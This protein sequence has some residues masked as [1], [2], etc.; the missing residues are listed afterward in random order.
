M[1]KIKVSYIIIFMLLVVIVCAII[2]QIRKI[3]NAKNSVVSEINIDDRNVNLDSSL[4]NEREIITIYDIEDGYMDV[5]FNKKADLHNYDFQKHLTKENE[6]YRYEDDTYTSKVGIDVSSYQGVIDWRKVKEDG[7]EF[8]ILR[9]GFRGYG[10]AGNIV[11]DSTFEKNYKNAKKEGIDIGIYFFSQAITTS[12]VKEEFEFILEHIKNKEI[13]YPIYFDL[14]KIK[15]DTARTDNLTLDEITKM[16]VEF[17][18]LV[19]NSGYI[20]GVY[21]NSKTFTTRLKLEEI[22]E[23]SKWYADYLDI[24][25]YPYEFSMW[26]Y[27]E[28]GKVNGII[29][30][31][32]IN[33]L[34]IKK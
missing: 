4:Y 10:D 15:N 9:L 29:T 5:K 31:T 17:C 7:I 1:K 24:P 12:E 22:N 30:D 20:P 25:M 11:L 14:E 16:T 6:R 28:K 34:F 32:D 8:A 26:Q 23:F 27:T 2:W 3:D 21:G 19:K 13:T 33:I 18:N